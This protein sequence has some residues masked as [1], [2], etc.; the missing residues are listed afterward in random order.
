MERKEV[1]SLD[2]IKSKLSHIES[3]SDKKD[4]LKSL[5][6]DDDYE[7]N[8]REIG[9]MMVDLIFDPS[10]KKSLEA[11]RFF[12]GYDSLSEGMEPIYF[13]VLDFMQDQKPGGLG[14]QVRKVSE[15]YEASVT[16]GYFGE[17]GQRTSL[18]QQKA[19]EYLGTIN[20]IIKSI[21]NLIYD[22]KEFEMRLAAYDKQKDINKEEKDAAIRSLKGIW[23]DQ[24]DA[25]K[26]RA[27]INLLA[28][29]LNFVTIRDAFFYI[30][31]VEDIDKID[32]NDRVKTILKR[33]L[34]EY[35]EW[36]KLSEKEIR[37]RYNVEKAYLK[38]QAAT[39]RVYAN[40][41]K[42]YLKAAQKLKMKE[43]NRAH[44]VNAFSNMEFEI[45]LHG[46]KEIK[47]EAVH[48]S[49]RDV[50][51]DKKYYA[52]IEVLMHFRSV[53]S[54][55]SGQGG[56]HYVHAGRT[57]LVIRGFAL[58]DIEL[59]AL[60][61]SEFD[62][63]LDLIEN[64]I[65][66]SLKEIKDEL[67]KYTKDEKPEKEEKKRS[68]KVAIDNPFAGTID[69][70][71]SMFAPFTETFQIRKSKPSFVEQQLQDVAAD[72]AKSMSFTIYNIYKKSHG[73][74]SP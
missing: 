55:M 29:D 49:F 47:P 27:S 56:R 48:E 14:L 19:M 25:R 20:N 12:L 34:H 15:D 63:D 18:M 54:V 17:I 38:S 57:E 45:K 51:L 59:G 53:P 1:L 23:M 10:S 60:E 43:F 73:M 50:S 41:V 2:E 9:R 69:S 71:K 66:T 3:S 74:L 65:G 32:L 16:S 22:L 70:F 68:K 30:N 28:Q 40:W 6:A 36:V 58:D 39:L 5:Y 64:Y 42:P 4:F 21:L 44:V 61:N 67:E 8:K 62:E 37:T 7:D 46:K 31:K 52:V 24:V 26:G 72:K 33:K 35:T 13:W 11:S